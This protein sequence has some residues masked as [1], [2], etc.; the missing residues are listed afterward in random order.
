MKHSMN[1]LAHSV[2]RFLCDSWASFV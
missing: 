1:L 2:A